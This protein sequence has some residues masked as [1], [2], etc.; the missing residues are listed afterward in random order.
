MISVKSTSTRGSHSLRIKRG[1]RPRLG[2]FGN[3]SSSV[4]T[5]LSMLMEC[6]AAGGK[7]SG[8]IMAAVR[9][10][11]ARGIRDVRIQNISMCEPRQLLCDP[12]STPPHC[13]RGSASLLTESVRDAAAARANLSMYVRSLKLCI[14]WPDAHKGMLQGSRGRDSSV[15]WCASSSI[16]ALASSSGVASRS[17]P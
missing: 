11:R 15:L 6:E 10:R 8:K 12:W 1:V 4:A 3:Y 16:A 5:L 2:C 9:W 13:S 14:S 17:S 7:A